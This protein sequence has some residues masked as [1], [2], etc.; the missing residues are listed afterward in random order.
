MQATTAPAAT[1]WATASFVCESIS[2]SSCSFLTSRDAAGL[3][4]FWLV[5][6]QGKDTPSTGSE[7]RRESSNFDFSIQSHNKRQTHIECVIIF[8]LHY[9]LLSI[10]LELWKC[11]VER[12]VCCFDES[13]L[14]LSGSTR[15]RVW[16]SPRLRLGVWASVP[17]EKSAQSKCMQT[18]VPWSPGSGCQWLS[19]LS[20]AI[21]SHHQSWLPN[22]N[23]I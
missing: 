21:V 4:D 7:R 2:I 13:L 9:Y 16:L 10:W 1:D 23:L 20:H 12:C 8:I 18:W 5:S 22:Y 11:T 3:S 14:F 17:L 6:S 15:V 19:R